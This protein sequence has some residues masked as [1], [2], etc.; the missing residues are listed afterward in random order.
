[1]KLTRLT[2][3]SSPVNLDEAKAHLRITQADE[4]SL[5]QTYIDAAVEAVEAST[6]RQL[7]TA[8]FQYLIDSFPDEIKLP[9]PPLA[10]VESITYVDADGDSQTLASSLYQ[11]DSASQPAIIKP[12]YNKSWP[13][14]RDQFNAVEVLFDAGYGAAEDVP[15]SLKLCIKVLVGHY[16]EN[17]EMAAP[18]AL[19]EIPYSV[20]SILARYRINDQW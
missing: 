12:A 20:Q 16:Y 10:S 8:S 11:I 3:P 1:M 4:D 6:R 9:C 13:T 2:S 18:V 19:Q 7:V 15:D 17:R 5:I 14:T